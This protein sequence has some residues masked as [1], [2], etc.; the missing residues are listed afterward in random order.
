MQG[1]VH[2]MIQKQS[3]SVVLRDVWQAIYCKTADEFVI[4]QDKKPPIHTTIPDDHWD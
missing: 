2:F 4:N 3:L 1:T